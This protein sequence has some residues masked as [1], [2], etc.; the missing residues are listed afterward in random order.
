MWK[1][2]LSRLLRVSSLSL[3]G[4]LLLFLVERIIL[5]GW[6]ELCT[7][8]HR[9]MVIPISC[10][11]WE[12]RGT[13]L[14]FYQRQIRKYLR[15][16]ESRPMQ[17]TWQNHNTQSN[18]NEIWTEWTANIFCNIGGGGGNIDSQLLYWSCWEV[19]LEKLPIKQ[20]TFKSKWN[21]SQSIKKLRTCDKI[22]MKTQAFNSPFNDRW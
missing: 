20:T 4:D 16:A 13:I 10:P 5:V 2:S 21:S 15:C 22:Q 12:G 3:F 19:L 17:N 7:K 9:S 11:R 14:P 1:A 8:A 18:T 6:E